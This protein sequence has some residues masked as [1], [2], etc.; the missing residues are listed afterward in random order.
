V[1]SGRRKGWVRLASA[2]ALA[3]V[4]GCTRI[5][6]TGPRPGGFRFATD[7]FAFANVTI[8]EYDRVAASGKVVWRPRLP[9]PEFALRC[10]PMARSVRQFYANA[11]FDPAAPEA[12]EATYAE[13]IRRVLASDPRRP[14]TEP[15][16]IPG[17]ADLRSFS[18]AH[19]KLVKS[20]LDH[21]WRTYVQRGNWRMI[22]PF[23]PGQ[24]TNVADEMRAALARGWPPVVHV[25][26]YPELTVNHLM[27]AYAAE[28][29]PSEIRFQLYDPNDADG[30]VVLTW[31]RGAQAFAL[32]ATPYFPGGYVKAYTVYDGLV[33]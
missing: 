33:F 11:R 21:P 29:T 30:P 25:L 24:Q 32:Q 17:F 9:P 28:E 22:F 3:L 31:E 7:T 1:R 4:A 23:T 2:L 14:E 12:S 5:A 10:G 20:L 13:L 18:G 16:V 19:E 6:A 27:L 26:R 15:I 8:W